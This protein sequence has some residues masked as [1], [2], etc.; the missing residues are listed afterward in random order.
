MIQLTQT[1]LQSL[2]DYDPKTGDF[3]FL[4]RGDEEF[5]TPRA[6][7]IFR[8]KCL[9]KVAGWR[10]AAGYVAISVDGRTY[11]AHRL[12]WLWTTGTWPDDEIDHQNG[13]RAD[14]RIANLR[15]VSKVENS[16]NQSLRVTN[17]SGATGVFF[18]ARRNS[19]LATILN[20]GRS[21]HLGYFKT[22]EEA[23][24]ARK[25]AERA[26]RFDK[27]HGKARVDS[28]YYK[29]RGRLRP[30]DAPPHI[31]PAVDEPEHSAD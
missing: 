10:H 26:L 20:L 7:A 14:N 27:G 25:G 15:A 18:E 5:A 6:A 21:I 19:W 22:F 16:H 2:F 1:R 24:A 29:P 3:T 4:P 23:C 31:K 28:R 8:T 30:S 9:G 17:K 13:D 12:A 11:L